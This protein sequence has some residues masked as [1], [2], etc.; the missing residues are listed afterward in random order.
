MEETPYIKLIISLQISHSPVFDLS[1]T[2]PLMY[3]W[4]L[5]DFEGTAAVGS[6]LCYC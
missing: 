1:G 3:F 6:L 2:N 4:Q 5:I